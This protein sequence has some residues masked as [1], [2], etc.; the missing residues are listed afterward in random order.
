VTFDDLK[1]DG[2]DVIMIFFGA[3]L[4]PGPFTLYID[5]VRLK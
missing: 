2:A 5:N 1:I 3:V 4:D